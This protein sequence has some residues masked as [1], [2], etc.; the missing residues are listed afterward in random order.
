MVGLSFRDEAFAARLLE[1]TRLLH[2]KGNRVQ[3][4]RNCQAQGI[5]GYLQTFPHLW[6]RITDDPPREGIQP[7][8]QYRLETAASALRLA[9]FQESVLKSLNSS[10]IQA[11]AVKGLSL[12]LTLYGDISA[13]EFGDIDLL[14]SPQDALRAVEVLEADGLHRSYPGKMKPGQEFAFFKYLKAQN[15]VASEGRGQLDLHWRLLSSWVGVDLLPFEE[16]WGRSKVLE[17]D[18]LTPWRSLGDVDN[19]V[20][21]ALHGF[22]DGWPKLKQFLD[23]AVALEVLDFDWSEVLRVAGYRAVLVEQA[24]EMCVRL[25]DIPHPAQLTHHFR[26]FEHALSVW[27]KMAQ[28]PKSPQSKLLHPRY[29]SCQSSEAIVRSLDALFCP[30]ID[31]IQSI[32]LPSRLAPGYRAVRFFRLIKKALERRGSSEVLAEKS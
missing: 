4:V 24:V 17:R 26:D 1:L 22:Q 25:F 13:R 28:S 10:G 11:L 20:F 23:L 2:P 14:V 21:A 6:S 9:A 27:L 29:W 3:F 5:R 12:S 31:D 16:L 8:Q 7:A 15:L 30:A 32:E 19:L 18:G